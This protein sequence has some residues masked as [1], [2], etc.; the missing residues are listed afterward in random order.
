MYWITIATPIA[1]FSV[2]LLLYLSISIVNVCPNRTEK[3][4]DFH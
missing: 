4:L 1:L 2:T 3:K